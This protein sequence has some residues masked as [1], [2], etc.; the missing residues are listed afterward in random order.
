MNNKILIAEPT[1]T[2]LSEELKKNKF[3][4]DYFPETNIEQLRRI[5]KNYSGLV[6]RS[7]FI[8]NREVIDIGSNL[9]FIARA[10]SGMENIDVEYAEKKG[11]NC[12]NSPEG[13]GNAVGEHTLGLLLNL[14]NNISYSHKQ[15][16]NGIWNRKENKGI[17]LDGKTVGIIGYGNTGSSF[18]KKLRGFDVKIIAN[19]KFKKD[20]STD[21][22]TETTLSE[23]F[24]EADIV[25]VHIP[26]IKENEHFVNSDFISKFKKNVILINTSRGKIFK[27]VDV[28]NGLKSGKITGFCADVLEYENNSFENILNSGETDT[29]K[30][31][32]ESR[33]VI[34]TPHIA[35]SSVESYKKNSQVLAKK[36]IDFLSNYD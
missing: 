1:H 20:F 36:I 27:T 6:V 25:S 35:G 17:E 26:Y 30:F 7:R 2:Y 34:L 12:I 8:I 9:R 28:V 31:L 21:F 29:L 14:L 32:T 19:D 15:I 33:N 18:A 10:G 16:Q 23:L 22:V 11:I 4:F 3:D 24:N 13:N 5:I